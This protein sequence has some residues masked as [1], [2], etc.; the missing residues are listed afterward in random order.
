MKKIPLS[1]GSGH[2]FDIESAK[3]WT[4]SIDPD[5][6]DRR[7]REGPEEEKLFLTEKGSFIFHHWNWRMAEGLFFPL[8]EEKATRWLIANGY[9]REIP[10]LELQS[11]ERSLEL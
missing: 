11:E 6:Q 10:Q 2:W 1:D 3:S 5:E 7:A 9:Q 4:E 8:D